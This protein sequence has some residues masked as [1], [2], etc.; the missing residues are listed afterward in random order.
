MC[1]NFSIYLW[2]PGKLQNPS[3]TLHQT[4]AESSAHKVRCYCA[5]MPDWSQRA[6]VTIHGHLH[7]AL[8][9]ESF[10]VGIGVIRL[11]I[12]EDSNKAKLYIY[13]YTLIL[14]DLPLLVYC[15]AGPRRNR[16]FDQAWFGGS[17]QRFGALKKIK[18]FG[19][20]YTFT[21]VGGNRHGFL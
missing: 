21:W 4:Q 19:K 13:I 8:Q 5:L 20:D 10:S 6:V 12:L 15:L 14:S 7:M 16:G 9:L 3:D 2:I 11:L 1:P 18:I 17:T